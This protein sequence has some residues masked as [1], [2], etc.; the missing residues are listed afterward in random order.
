VDAT[1]E[2]VIRDRMAAEQTRTEPPA[3]AVEVPPIPTARYTDIAFAELEQERIFRRSWLFVGHRSEWPAAGSYRQ[4]DRTGSPLVVVRGVDDVIRAFHNACRHRGAPVTRDE[5]GTARRLTCQ[6]HSWSYGLDGQLLA[7]P[8]ARSFVDL[9]TD[10]LGLAPVRCEEWQDWVFIS[11][12]PAAPPLEEF[13]GPLADQMLDID[14]PSLRFVGTQSHHLACNW[15]LMVDA[16]LEVYHVRTVHPDNAALLYDDQSA[17]VEMLPNG[18]SRLTVDKRPELRDLAFV[19]PEFDNPSVPLLWRQTSTSFGIFPNLVVPMDTGAFTFLC[20]WPVDVDHTEL[21]LRWYAPA[22]D[23]DE[24]PDAHA[25]RMELFA[26]VMAQD[27]AN[28]AP[29]QASVASSGIDAFHIG[30]HE[31]LIHH[32]HRAVDLAVGA[33]DVPDGL[34]VSDALDGYVVD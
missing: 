32:F 14:G 12:D 27:T 9:R 6:Y 18:H 22:W 4:F 28:M 8:D 24:V 20:M 15:K 31:R 11:E 19:P 33:D 3:D 34:A 25:D 21:E 5:C 29:I 16:F 10:E 17:T 30:W 23:G 7:V 26:T 1:L 2:Q 13:L